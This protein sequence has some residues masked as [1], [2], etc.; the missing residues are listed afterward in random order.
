MTAEQPTLDVSGLPAG[1][2]G[3]AALSDLE[4][5]VE[6]GG[7]D[8][9]PMTLTLDGQPVNGSVV[10]STMVYRPRELS[11]GEHQFAAELPASG[12]LGF[13]KSSRTGS[14]SFTVDATPP[15][16]DI[17][18]I[19]AVT[20]Y[21]DGVTVSGQTD[22]AN[23]LTIDGEDVTLSPDGTF[24]A[25]LP[26]VPTN[27]KVVATDAAGN[28]T[29]TKISGSV[30][31]PQIRAVHVTAHAWAHD[32]LRGDVLDMA[33]RGLIN[34]V[35]LDIKDEDGIVG[36]DS[37]VPL[38]KR[39]G[40]NA[41]IYDPSA[42]LKKLHRMDIRVIGRIVAFRDPKLAEWAW[43]HGHHDWVIQHP[44]GAP[45]ASKYGP[46]AFTNFA[47]EKVRQ[48]NIDL[49][50]E[51]AELGF[52]GIM[53]D[54]IRRPDGDL[55][56][57][58]FP[59]LD[60]KPHVSV[61]RFLKES[62]EPVRSAGAHLSAAVFGIAATRPHEIAQDIPMMAEH[63]DYLSPMV[64]PS[65]WNQGEYDVANPNSQPYPIVRR[66]LKDFKRQVRGTE[67]KIIPW[68]QDFSLGVS[69]GDAQVAAQISGAADAGIDSFFLWSPSVRYHSGALG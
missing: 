60:V 15:T 30:T 61:A 19:P 8:P 34:A 59:G 69:Y 7:E 26:H 48:Y 25:D 23:Q 54:Y 57:M 12:P 11:D 49:A 28:Q 38:A 67:A 58:A 37:E 42:A 64:Y 51:A 20:S 2:I 55:S 4:L 13:L 31:T 3:A 66:S 24:E 22:G 16:L 9:S 56:G 29:S 65:H 14:R 35:Q 68:L 40:A 50:T 27:T 62:R 45:Y 43:R 47:H 18:E 41:G 53:Y 36:Y 1:L 6:T 63:V 5:R 17:D 39:S 44:G 10:G 52:D 46:I 21:R 33:R 32:G